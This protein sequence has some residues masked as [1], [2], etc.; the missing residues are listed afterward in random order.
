MVEHLSSMCMTLNL[1]PRTEK[2]EEERKDKKKLV[3]QERGGGG[4]SPV[5]TAAFD[6]KLSEAAHEVA[7]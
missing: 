2:R 6:R 7:G 4:E 1:I 3:Q 5:S